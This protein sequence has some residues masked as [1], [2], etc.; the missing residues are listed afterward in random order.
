MQ[1]LLTVADAAKALTISPWTL[2]KWL[3][4]KRLAY[5]K[6]GRRVAISGADI[7][8]LIRKGRIEAGG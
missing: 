3:A 7:E 8:T 6:L 2:R 4:T 1:E 5:V